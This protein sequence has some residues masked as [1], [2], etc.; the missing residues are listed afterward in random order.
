MRA[1]KH[2]RRWLLF[3]SVFVVLGLAVDIGAPLL[4]TVWAR[5]A[6][7]PTLEQPAT[8]A[9]E[10]LEGPLCLSPSRPWLCLL[11]YRL[12]LGGGLPLLN[13]WPAAS[14]PVTAPA[15]VDRSD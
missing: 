8:A 10:W 14:P 9:S 2:I 1:K 5:G 15:E 12:R 13:G 4:A 11:E 7:T 3:A 6:G